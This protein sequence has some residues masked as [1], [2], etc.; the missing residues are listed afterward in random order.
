MHSK[1]LSE[2]FKRKYFSDPSR[3]ERRK[4]LESK[5]TA[6]AD[7]VNHL[8]PA[9]KLNT[10]KKNKT[11]LKKLVSDFDMLESAWKTYGIKQNPTN[12]KTFRSKGMLSSKY[13]ILLERKQ[14]GVFN[15][16]LLSVKELDGKIV[17]VRIYARK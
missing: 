17:N 8:Q 12:R 3:K 5:G 6:L 4:Y 16:K 2:L 9:G 7:F 10:G 11:Y 13:H 14:A 1:N 15:Q